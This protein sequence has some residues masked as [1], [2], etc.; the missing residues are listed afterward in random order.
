G[1]LLVTRGASRIPVGETHV[2]ADDTTLLGRVSAYARRMVAT[3]TSVATTRRMMLALGLS[4]LGWAGQ[5]ATFH[6][7]ALA[8]DL[9]ITGS[10]SLLAL[11]MVNASFVVRLTPGNVGIFQLL[12]AIAATAAGLDRERA[13]AAAFLITAVQ[14]IPVVVI[15]LPLVP[16]LARARDHAPPLASVSNSGRR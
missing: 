14:Y 3:M 6:Y 9:P 15:G 16:S 12:Y 8:T 4:I 5:W 1:G 2:G 11:L 7:A 10:Q 13:I